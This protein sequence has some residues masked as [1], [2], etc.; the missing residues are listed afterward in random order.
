VIRHATLSAI[1]VAALLLTACASSP[2]AKLAP[3]ATS[4]ASGSSVGATATPTVEA[5]ST[6][7]VAAPS[8]AGSP[9]AVSPV[10]PTQ[11]P[12]TA[13]LLG[14][15]VPYPLP[16]VIPPASHAR[17]II[18]AQ[19]AVLDLMGRAAALCGS[20]FRAGE[21][22]AITVV[23]RLGSTSWQSTARP[24]GTFT[25]VVPVSACRLMPIYATARGN[26][27]SVADSVRIAATSCRLTA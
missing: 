7:T 17:I 14:C 3:G 4:P 16:V 22:V 25:S 9:S 15:P 19:S 27:G 5:A 13:N 10:R 6:P 24:D 8:A 26:R 12:R 11:C 20:G 23:G 2:Q 18:C 1:F 21:L